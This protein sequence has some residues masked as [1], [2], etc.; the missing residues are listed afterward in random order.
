MLLL[1]FNL[2]T[3][4]FGMEAKLTRRVLPVVNLREVPRT[5]DFVRGV[6]EFRGQIVPVI[7]LQVLTRQTPCALR[8]STRIL[9]VDYEPKGKDSVKLP[10]GLLAERVT[11]AIEV[12][13]S[14]I[15]KSGMRIE[16]APYL[17][18]LA[19]DSQ[20]LIQLIQLHKILPKP[21]QTILYP[22]DV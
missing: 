19:A 6:F 15:K 1:L 14:A 21:L 5:P 16:G 2:G 8:F 3:D 22:S 17:G 7:D 13:E 10:L 20:G 4:R 11:E 12:D 18:D 9:L